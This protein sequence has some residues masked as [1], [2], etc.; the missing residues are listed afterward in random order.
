MT[1]TCK[2]PGCALVAG[3]RGEHCLEP[4]LLSERLAAV[5][6]ERDALRAALEELFR[7]HAPATVV[8]AMV[9]AALDADAPK[10]GA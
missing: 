6:E 10:G 8:A 7:G 4:A 5:T 1:T 9:R 2:T 3:H